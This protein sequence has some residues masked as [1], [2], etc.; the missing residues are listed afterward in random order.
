MKVTFMV[1]FLCLIGVGI[2]GQNPAKPANDESAEGAKKQSDV[3][4]KQKD[5]SICRNCALIYVLNAANFDFSGKLSTSYLFRF[6]MFAPNLHKTPFGFNAGIEKINYTTG[7]INGDDSSNVSYYQQNFVVNPLQINRSY[8]DTLL[9]GGK[10]IQEYNQYTYTNSNTVWSF[11]FQPFLKIA[12]WNEVTSNEG[13]YF[14]LHVEL[15]VNEWTRTATIKN[16][17][18]NP[19]TS[20]AIAPFTNGDSSFYWVKNNPIV[21]HYNIITGNFGGGITFYTNLHTALNDTATHFWGQATIG[22]SVNGPN[23]GLLNNPGREPSPNGS[24]GT[25]LFYN[26]RPKSFY[27]IRMNF[28]RSLSSTSQLML[29]GVFRGNLGTQNVQYAAYLG[30]NVDLGAFAH[31]INGN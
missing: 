22:V 8:G 9:N 30:L 27:L 3:T 24:Y 4:D 11:Y 5:T 10:Y 17:Y 15:L 25:L 7:T 29:G 26:P 19:D 21:S 1:V 14:H 31:L 16:L 20:I 6:N 18:T 13:L 23:F 2:Y 12:P 28:T